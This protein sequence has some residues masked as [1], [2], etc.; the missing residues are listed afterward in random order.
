MSA[1]GSLKKKRGFKKKV[2]ESPLHVSPEKVSNKISKGDN[3][4]KKKD[5]SIVI[6][7]PVIHE[8]EHV[9][10]QKEVATRKTGV[11]KRLKKMTHNPSLTLQYK[12]QVTR[13][14]VVFKK[15]QHQFLLNR[16]KG[17]LSMA[18]HISTEQ[19]KHKKQRKLVLHEHSTDEEMVHE[20]PV[21]KQIAYISLV[22]DS[23]V[24]SNFKET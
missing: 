4:S 5:P 22:R 23:L 15:F 9:V 17:V 10:L 24:Q 3:V 14:G 19:K 16:R 13:K 18:K 21:T 12:K 11:L 2:H 1:E 20:M 6:T 7:E 8:E